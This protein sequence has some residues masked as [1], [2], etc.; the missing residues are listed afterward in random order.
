MKKLSIVTTLLLLTG[1]LHAQKITPEQYINTYKNLA[2]S[3]MKRT[4]IPASVTLAQGLLETEC[5][6]S[7][8]VQKSNNH[9][10]I[11]CKST[12]T[13]ESVTHTD[14]APNECFR[15]YNKPEES[16][17][18]HSDYLS[19][20]PRYASLFKLDAA[21][22]RGWCY[23][24]KKCGYA[25]NP[26]YP[27]ILMGNIEKYNLQQFDSGDTAAELETFADAKV[28]DQNSNEVKTF[29]IAPVSYDEKAIDN[30]LKGKVSF[31]KLKAL[32]ANKGTSLLAIATRAD[33]PLVKLLEYNDLKTDGLLKDDQWIYLEK[34]PKEGNRDYYVA[35]QT[36]T[37][38]DIS[39]NNGVQLQSLM[40]LNNMTENET[41]SKGRKI[42]LRASAIA[43]SEQSTEQVHT[44]QPKEGL[45]AISK[46]YNVPVQQ[47]KEL[48]DLS[49]DGLK[50]GQQL[51][52]SK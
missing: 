34:K 30:S 17:R 28:I 36:E 10:G 24:L 48:N 12:W 27:Q 52:I 39:Q 14:D 19:T 4:G 33:I 40:Q 1:F 15:K 44:V 16:Y 13:G 9:F 49:D 25:T 43:A 3:E 47:I 21:D 45:Y 11:K 23:G 37:L 32:F 46:K 26:R 31:N 20:S 51:I 7:E 2:I 35:L 50:P 8:L 6:N 38:Y 42:R 29:T 22:Y 41:V 5:G 18:D